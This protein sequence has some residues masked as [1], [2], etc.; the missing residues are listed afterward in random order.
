MGALDWGIVGLYCAAMVAIGLHFSRQAAKSPEHFFLADRNMPWWMIGLADV[1]SYGV[2]GATWVTLFWLDGFNE[3]WLIAWVSWCVWMPL[4]AVLWSKMWRRLGVVTTGELIERRYSGRGA[5]I[6]RAVYGCYAYWAWAVVLLAYVSAWFTQTIA[7]IL[8]WTA[9]EVLLVFGGIT[10]VYTLLAG[11]IGVVYTEIIQFFLIMAGNLILM[12]IV[13]GQAGGLDAI[14]AGIAAHRPPEFLHPLPGGEKLGMATLLTLIVQGLFFA[15]SPMAGE[16]WTAQRFMA[17]RNERHAVLGQMFSCVL[18]LVVRMIPAV[19]I[20]LAAVVLY[21]KARLSEPT[22]LWAHIVSDYAPVGVMGLLFA[23]TLASFMSGVSSTINWGSSY[24]LN[25]VYRRH[26]RKDAPTREYVLVSR[27]LT[28]V[29]L[30]VSLSIGLAIDPS[31][32]T[33]WVVFI[34]S[35]LIVFSLPLAWLKWFWWRMNIFGDAVGMLGAFPL[36][37]VVC[38]GSNSVLPQSVR[39]WS[40][41]ALGWNLELF[42]P[43]FGDTSA[44]PFWQGFLILFAAGWAAIL[45]ATLLTRPEDP[46]VLKA[47]YRK[48]RPIGFWG[49]IAR[50]VDAETLRET[51]RETRNDLWACLCGVCFCFLLVVAFFSFSG[52][53]LLSLGA[54]CAVLSIPAGVMFFRTALN[55]AAFS[56]PAAPVVAT[57]NVQPQILDGAAPESAVG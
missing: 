39:D 9:A 11:F 47:F 1:T 20:G 33:S 13:I 55:S 57:A 37:F 22:T 31:K 51:A 19:F 46:E 44:H 43:A 24:L 52:Q 35:A 36:A 40:L 6:Y 25:D 56:R 38:F 42:V 54:G 18:S 15:G 10:L 34:N 21:P 4:V 12:A 30:V 50:E 32:L 8:G 27:V 41:T 14:Y 5:G 29:T 3:Y 53:K 2:G 26:V 16:G 48:V 17:A 28:A 7:P 45:G 49:P 23:G